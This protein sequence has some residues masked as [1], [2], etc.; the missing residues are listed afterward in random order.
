VSWLDGWELL[1]WSG[2]AVAG[3]AAVAGALMVLWFL[4]RP[5]PPRVEVSSHVLWDRVAPK[6]RNPLLKELLMLLLQLAM[7]AA[8]ALA[9]GDPRFTPPPEDDEGAAPVLAPLDRVHVV[10]QSLSMDARAGDGSRLDAVIDAIA[11][12]VDGLPDTVRVALIGAGPIAEILAPIAG[13]RARFRLA[14]RTLGTAGVGADLA[15][16]LVQAEAMPG[17]RSGDALV[18]LWSDDPAAGDALAAWSER[19]GIQGRVRV[20]FGPAGSLAITAFDLG[21]ARGIP[22]EEE[23][24]VRVA[25]PTPWPATATL[26]LE[27]EDA[28][29]GRAVLELA[30]GQELERRYRFLPLPGTGV[31]A[32]LRDVVFDGAPD[33]RDA[34]SADDRAYAWVK[35]VDPVTVWL[36]S[37]GNRFLER[38]LTVLPGVQLRRITPAEYRA[39]KGRG[40]ADADVVFFDG[41]VPLDKRDGPMPRRAVL[42]APPASRSPVPVRGVAEE[43]VVTDWDLDHPLFAGLVLRDLEVRRSL[44]FTPEP[45]DVR[46]LGTTTGA[47]VVG[48]AD[49]DRRLVVW[50]FDLGASDL[51]L[52]LAF[53]QTIVNTVLWMR[54][55]RPVEP[56]RG[57]R[58]DLETPTWLEGDGSV[59][60]T[61][62]RQA[63]YAE[64]AG[65]A[66]ALGRAS[67]PVSLGDGPTPYRF[68]RPGLYSI[69]GGD[70]RTDVGVNL[71]LLDESRLADLPAGDAGPVPVPRPADAPSEGGRL[72]WVLLALGAAAVG[73]VEFGMYTR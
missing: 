62:L 51:P 44:V 11:D 22:A 64:A 58:H 9:L 54:D 16:A 67:W 24:L 40:A 45:G 33:P 3:T 5:R 56:A 49:G 26:A 50:G 47:L 73:L 8:I 23:A 15:G 17:L 30:P 60:V 63:A 37:D 27:T 53:P 43:P 69:V 71:F 29:L 14:L 59:V 10:D 66:L 38:V 65:D 61:D 72:P 2:R 55:S 20:P 31:E 39:G 1:G 4:F 52:R 57:E 42:L 19:T 36:V 28:R 13:D 18:E 35:P 68:P 25:N 21:A 7:V 12:D 41:F 48:R 6:R 46:L 70:R 32:V 34:L